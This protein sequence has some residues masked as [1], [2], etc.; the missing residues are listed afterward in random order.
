MSPAP[1]I[2]CVRPLRAHPL[3]NVREKPPNLTVEHHKSESR[4]GSPHQRPS[5]PGPGH[6]AY[7]GTIRARTWTC[8]SF[9]KHHTPTRELQRV[10]TE[11][12]DMDANDRKCEGIT[13][14]TVP[15]ET[16]PGHSGRGKSVESSHVH[17]TTIFLGL[18]P[19]FQGGYRELADNSPSLH[20]LFLST[21]APA[22]SQW[23]P[24]S[25][26]KIY[27]PLKA[28]RSSTAPGEDGLLTLVWRCLWK[29]IG[30]TITRVFAA[31]LDLDYHPRR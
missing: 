30:N 22:E 3:L 12:K 4:N 5:E 11:A 21:N 2:H 29:Y 15:L 10:A 20:G 14:E 13:L 28:T 9:R 25:E 7:S 31:F 19:N 16:V 26:L 24:I 27:Q 23:H 18:R 1:A 17:D 6:A 8:C